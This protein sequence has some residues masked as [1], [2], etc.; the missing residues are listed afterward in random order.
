MPL[1]EI[2]MVQTLTRREFCLNHA[3]LPCAETAQPPKLIIIDENHHAPS[4][5]YLH[6]L[7]TF[8]DTYCVGL[9][10]TPVRLGRGGLGKVNDDLIIGPSVSELI[11]MG[12]LSPFRYFSHVSADT[13][14]LQVRRGEFVASEVAALMG[15]SKIYGG[16]VENYRRYGCAKSIAYC[17]CIKNSEAAAEAF[18]EA[19]VPAAHVDANT[20]A[21]RRGEIMSDFRAGRVRVL[22]NVDLVSEGFD[23][24]DCDS[25]LLM[26]PTMSLTLHIQQSMR[27]M[28]PGI[29]PE[30]AKFRMP[31]KT[32]VIVDMAENFRRHGLPDTPR[33]WSLDFKE[34]RTNEI[35]TRVC[36]NCYK[37]HDSNVLVCDCGFDMRMA[38]CSHC[39]NK[40]QFGFGSCVR[41]GSPLE[42][43]RKR[44]VQRVAESAM[45]EIKSF[46]YMD[47]KKC[48]S[49]AELRAIQQARGYKSGWIWY[50]AKELGLI[51]G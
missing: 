5:S 12:H 11:G 41:C 3:K 16:A 7:D 25:C 20:S 44:D 2:A 28:R 39:G 19:G 4:A 30:S 45:D 37:V 22:C 51:A 33:E 29:S 8:A 26:R 31:G 48:R 6:I 32:A 9:T 14:K 47:W 23:V 13:S 35:T 34:K 17:D 10:A 36:E 43:G 15:Q 42:I 49:V 50:R 21:A 27:C 24:P 1:C 38:E 18:R 46:T 40:Q